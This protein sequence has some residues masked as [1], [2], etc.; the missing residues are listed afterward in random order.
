LGKIFFIYLLTTKQYKY[1][2]FKK[3]YKI[4]ED[5]LYFYF[6]K[7]NLIEGILICKPDQNYISPACMKIILYSTFTQSRCDCYWS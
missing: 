2:K 3:V 7:S 1:E 6:E 5:P 4:L